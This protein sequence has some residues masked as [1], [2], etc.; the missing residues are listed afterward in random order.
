MTRVD[1]AINVDE[2]ADAARR[3]LPRIVLDYLEGG[4][5][6]ETTLSANRAA[7]ARWRLVPDLLPQ[8]GSP[9][10]SVS[11]F[12]Q[13]LASPFIVGPTGLNGIFRRGADLDLARAAR[14]AGVA[15][16][17]SSASNVSLEDIA[18]ELPESIRWFQLYPWGQAPVRNRL[19]ERAQQSGYSALIV[20]VDALISG[21]RE[22][23]LRNGFAH[24]LRYTPRSIWQGLTHLRWMARA[25]WPQGMP[26]FE[27]IAEF[28]PAGAS[29]A[30]L[31]NFVRSQKNTALSWTDLADIR[32][33]WR[34]PL[35]IKGVLSV[36]DARRARDIGAD[37]I[38][39][40]NHG[41]RQLDGAISTLDALDAIAQDAG[42]GL[43][44]LVDGGFRRG[45]DVLKAFAL[46]AKAVVLGRTPLYGVA[47]A[48]QSGA[49][50]V[51]EILRDETS[52]SLGLLGCR[53]VAQVGPGHV[54]K[55]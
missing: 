23:D 38:V 33:R 31:A 1:R 40:S 47:A 29:A 22:R 24:Q 15:F 52:R 3:R 32:N 37:G 13:Q 27:N 55:I 11:L 4:A 36:A 6:D 14:E 21:K 49:A 44:L 26:R 35:L 51:L 16:A 18:R 30:D 19:I 17:L 50:R 25:W 10:L 34:G 8:T 2:V 53:D 39:I 7:F 42:D 12:G 45:T 48:G 41:G 5:E 9:S 43:T 46:G 28:L 54:Q 20:T